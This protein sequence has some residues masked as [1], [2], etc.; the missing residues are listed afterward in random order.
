MVVGVTLVV[1]VVVP[2]K[3]IQGLTKFSK[4]A[5]RFK[6]FSKC[7]PLSKKGTDQLTLRL[8]AHALMGT[9]GRVGESVTADDGGVRGDRG[10]G[11][12]RQVRV[13]LIDIEKAKSLRK[14]SRPLKIVHQGPSCVPA[15]IHTIEQVS[16]EEEK[17][18]LGGQIYT[19]SFLL[20]LK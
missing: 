16:W 4:F 7:F 9:Q 14:A 20:Y 11:Y 10:L 12:S 18:K 5:E 19:C 1:I 15:D 8:W 2:G 13:R 17:E 3:K 6:G